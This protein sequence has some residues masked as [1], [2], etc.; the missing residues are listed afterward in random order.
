MSFGSDFG[1]GTLIVTF[2]GGALH[3]TA[4]LAVVWPCPACVH[5]ADFCSNG[6]ALPAGMTGVCKLG[7]SNVRSAATTVNCNSGGHVL[8]SCETPAP[9]GARHAPN[10]V[11]VTSKLDNCKALVPL[12]AAV[13]PPSA[14]LS[15]TIAVATPGC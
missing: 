7:S 13:P 15:V 8:P 10:P 3:N 12:C 1:V 14:D 6:A 5:S 11:L 9:S 4:A 2:G